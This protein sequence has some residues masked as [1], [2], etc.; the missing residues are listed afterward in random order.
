MYIY[1]NKHKT[2]LFNIF[3]I[4]QCLTL[5]LRKTEG[6]SFLKAISVQYLENVQNYTIYLDF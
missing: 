6:K 5:F 1:L 2:E 3:N 4:K